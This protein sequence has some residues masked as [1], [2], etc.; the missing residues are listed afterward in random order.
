MDHPPLRQVRDHRLLARRS[1]RARPARGQADRRAEQ[2]RQ[3]LAPAERRVDPGPRR[4]QRLR[5]VQHDPRGR[6]LPARR[7]PH[8]GRPGRGRGRR[9]RTTARSTR[10]TARSSARSRR[11][12]ARPP[13]SSSRSTSARTAGT[14]RP[15][16]SWA[17]APP[18]RTAR[19]G[20]TSTSPDPA[21]QAADSSKAF[22]GLDS[23]LL[24]SAV[25]V[26]IL[27]LLLTYRSPIL[28]ILPVISAG[29]ALTVSQAVIYLL[30]R[31]RRPHRERAER[32]HPHRP[33]VR[34]GDRLRPAA[35]RAIS[36]R[37]AQA[38][39]QARGDGPGPAPRQPGDHRQ[40]RH[41]RDLDAGAAA[42]LDRV[43]RGP[44]PGRRHRH[45]RRRARHAHAPA[46]PA[47]HLR[48]LGVLA[49]HAQARRRG[50]VGARLLVPGGHPHRASPAPH[51][52]G[53]GRDPAH[54]RASASSR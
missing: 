2:R 37:A 25:G 6:R 44:R 35:D 20:W 50:A 33:G 31:Q 54:R 49:A 18:R 29:V 21:G 38:R 26:V 40:R 51:L 32:R 48:P 4:G 34:G 24:F 19:T 14:S 36:R 9:R 53:H 52:G 16:P 41:R 17:C 1:R 22:E 12:T 28:W 7:R 8:A 46:R 23:T 13:R 11:R 42:R 3:V 43:H 10:S 5:L 39:R 27:I 15:T 47:R 45:R 30:A